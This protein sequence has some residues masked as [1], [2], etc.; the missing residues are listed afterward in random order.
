MA[1][2]RRVAGM[3]HV[4]ID[5]LDPFWP[6]LISESTR[7][8]TS[9]IYTALA[10]KGY[11]GAQIAAADQFPFWMER[12]AAVVALERGGSLG[13]YSMEALKLLDPMEMIEKLG[14][15]LI[16]GNPTSPGESP[17]GGVAHGRMAASELISENPRV[18]RC[19]PANYL[20]R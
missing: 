2:Q 7:D 17:I 11:T 10:N 13:S 16:N 6:D 14:V 19:D 3:L 8:A 15:I 9:D 5:E 1:V 18:R 4:A 20:W 12:R